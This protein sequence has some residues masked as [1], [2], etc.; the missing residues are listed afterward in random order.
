MSSISLSRVV[1]EPQRARKAIYAT[2]SGTRG[3]ILKKDPRK[4]HWDGRDRATV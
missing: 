2:A 1:V 3:K 4:P